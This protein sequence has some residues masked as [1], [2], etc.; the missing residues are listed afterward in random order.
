MSLLAAAAADARIVAFCGIPGVGKSLLLREQLTLAHA[1]GR[2]VTRLQWDVARQAFE[3][4]EIL[5]R[6]PEIDGSTHV[7]IRRAVGLWVR[8]AIAD[9]NERRPGLNELL[10]IEAPLVAGRMTELASPLA[11][12]AEPLLT[13]ATT[14][15][16]VPTPTRGVR[17]AIE[18]ARRA[19]MLDPRHA[20]DAAN[21]PPEL[22][23]AL[24]QEVARAAA[25]LR[26]ADSSPGAGYSPGLYYAVYASLLRHRRVTSLPIERVLANAASPHAVSVTSEELAPRAEQVPALI[27]QAEAEGLKAIANRVE[28]WYRL[29]PP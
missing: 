13:A 14:Q 16:F 3:I 21:A 12:R 20:R 1:A 9:W 24:W 7:T 5:S 6:Y 26:L 4:P 23:D 19:E 11:D 17:R 2:R 15:F 18:R 27:A 29:T 10:L 25:R 22:V 28:H 8:D